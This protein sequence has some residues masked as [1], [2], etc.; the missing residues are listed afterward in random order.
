MKKLIKSAMS[1]FQK[2]LSKKWNIESQFP[3]IFSSFFNELQ[4][5]KDI[6]EL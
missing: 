1:N 3:W 6:E 4:L 2:Y 5:D